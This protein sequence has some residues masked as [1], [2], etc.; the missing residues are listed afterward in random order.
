VAGGCHPATERR[1]GGKKAG[2]G[3][4]NLGSFWRHASNSFLVTVF[5]AGRR[6][7]RGGS[8]SE[9][10]PHLCRCGKPGMIRR[11]PTHKRFS[12][13]D[14]TQLSSHFGE[15]MSRPEDRPRLLLLPDLRDGRRNRQVW[16]RPFWLGRQPAPASIW[17]GANRRWLLTRADSIGQIGRKR[18]RVT[19]DALRKTV[20]RHQ[21]GFAGQ[22]GV[23]EDLRPRQ[24]WTTSAISAGRRP[25]KPNPLHRC[26]LAKPTFYDVQV[27]PGRT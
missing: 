2:G 18:F 15:A 16:A 5:F 8:G 17:P 4:F 19:E 14:R 6:P 7:P 25:H 24:R 26:A 10:F 9:A 3:C 20:A 22:R 11:D 27:L 21:N 12:S 13:G 1:I 23:D